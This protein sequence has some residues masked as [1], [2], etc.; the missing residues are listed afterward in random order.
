ML[1]SALSIAKQSFEKRDLIDLVETK[2]VIQNEIV[3]MLSLCDQNKSFERKMKIFEYTLIPIVLLLT[4]VVYP[5]I[6]NVTKIV[7]KV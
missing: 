2:R 3:F 7:Q 5:L 6:S 1:T 4:I